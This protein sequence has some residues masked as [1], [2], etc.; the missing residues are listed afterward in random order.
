MAGEDE[1][2]AYIGLGG[3]YQHTVAFSTNYVARPLVKLY[4]GESRCTVDL[5]VTNLKRTPME[6]MYLAHINFRPVDNGELVYSAPPRR[7]MCG[8][9]RASRRTSR[10]APA[11]ASSWRN[12]SRTRPSTTCSAP[13]LAF[14]PEIVFTIDYL[15]DD[16]GWAHTM[17][18]HPDG[19]ADYV[20]HRPE[21]LDKGVRWICRTPDQDALGLVLPA[22]AEPEGY[23]AEKAKGNIKVICRRAAALPATWKW[24]CWTPRPQQMAATSH[25]HRRGVIF[26]SFR[27]AAGN[28][29]SARIWIAAEIPRSRSE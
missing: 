25:D 5:T 29:L 14:D 7:S 11:I 4:A 18:V 28:L 1:R 6:L 20:R 27:R 26:L 9:A 24:A 12:W 21:Q 19:G 23:T 2:G 17:Q 16:D 13:D 10:P 3:A 8:C 15:A 22:T